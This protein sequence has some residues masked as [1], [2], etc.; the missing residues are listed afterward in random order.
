[1]ASMGPR[2]VGR[3]YRVVFH[4]AEGSRHASMGPRPVGR[5]YPTTELTPQPAAWCFNGAATSRSRILAGP[6]PCCE[7]R[8]GFNG[9]ATSRSRILGVVASSKMGNERFN[10]AATSRSRIRDDLRII[11]T[12][13]GHAS[14][15]P[16]PVGRGYG[17][18]TCWRKNSRFCFNGAATSRSRI[19][20]LY[21]R[22]LAHQPEL[23]WGR[24]Q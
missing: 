20:D 6:L 11:I 8:H 7:T 2:P 13:Q 23:Q 1:L 10:G 15:G 5:G 14:M 4:Y 12:R 24:D 22:I 9:A 16:R 21:R 17:L 3:G 18:N 19:P